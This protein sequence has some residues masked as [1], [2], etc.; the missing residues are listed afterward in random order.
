MGIFRRGTQPKQCA[1]LTVSQEMLES[2]GERL[3]SDQ[4]PCASYVD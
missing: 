4:L 3:P 2:N 1:V